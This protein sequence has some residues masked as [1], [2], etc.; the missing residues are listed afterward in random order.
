MREAFYLPSISD[1]KLYTS[2]VWQRIRPDLNK[3]AIKEKFQLIDYPILII[4]LLLI[5]IGLFSVFSATMY[6]PDPE[7]GISDPFGSFMTQYLSVIIG[8]VGLGILLILPFQLFKEINLLLAV[9]LILVIVL[10]LT[11]IVGVIMGGAKSWIEI[12]GFSFQPSELAKI[13]NILLVSYIVSHFKS[14]RIFSSEIFNNKH[15][16][17]AM[18][19]L[20]ATI[21]LV[22]LQPDFGMLIIMLVTLA[23]IYFPNHYSFKTNVV[24]LSLSIILYGLIILLANRYSDQLVNS[25]HYMLERIGS[26]V[27]PFAFEQTAGYQ[28]INGY[29]AFSR[30]G[31]FGVGLGLGIT[32]RGSLPAGHTD[33]ILAVIGEE[34]GLVGVALVLMLIFGLVFYLYRRAAMCRQAYNRNVISGI[35]SLFLIQ[36]L[37]NVGGISGLIPL[38]GVTLPFIS[39]GGTSMIVSLIAIGIAEIFIIDDK[40]VV[41]SYQTLSVIKGEGGS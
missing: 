33:F 23:F 20:F 7:T 37:V 40:R 22:G 8:F 4:T 28:L 2:K 9:Q 30:G 13:T 11:L 21:V 29:L 34:T 32:K 25:G 24:F 15:S 38:T 26:F 31:F 16:L 19:L 39:S 27:D 36:T 17:M 10:I 35:A 18:V 14:L 6:I 1:I 12:G 3:D 41:A 5:L